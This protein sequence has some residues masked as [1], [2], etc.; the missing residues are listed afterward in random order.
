MSLEI[1]KA[2]NELTYQISQAVDA[3]LPNA[4]S[5]LNANQAAALST[6]IANRCKNFTRNHKIMPQ[7]FQ[8][9]NKIAPK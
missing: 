4:S 7:L 2:Q 3:A 5:T 1:Q 9:Y 8:H 6:D